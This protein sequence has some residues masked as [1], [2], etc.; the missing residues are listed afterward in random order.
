M[1]LG[2]SR[3]PK[4]FSCSHVQ[5]L[6]FLRKQVKHCLILSDW[7]MY[8]TLPLV[9][10]HSKVSCPPCLRIHLSLVRYPPSSVDPHK[11]KSK[12]HQSTNTNNKNHCKRDISNNLF[13][14]YFFIV[15]FFLSAFTYLSFHS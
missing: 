5:S 12:Q 6:N 10:S 9:Q 2:S 11:G 13:S 15:N 14:K 4:R 7:A 1:Y 8:I 3:I